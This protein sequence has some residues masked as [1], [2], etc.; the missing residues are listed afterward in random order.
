MILAHPP[1]IFVVALT[2]AGQNSTS[3]PP[4]HLGRLLLYRL[5]G[6]HMVLEI[7]VAI[8][9]LLLVLFF[10]NI[11]LP[12]LIRSICKVIFHAMSRREFN[13]HVFSSLLLGLTRGFPVGA[14]NFFY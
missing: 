7:R 1:L 5:A 14:I 6:F 2:I 13:D 9:H 11:A 3:P 12:L 8:S 4:H 10:T